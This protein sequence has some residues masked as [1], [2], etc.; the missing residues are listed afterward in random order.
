MNAFLQ[1]LNAKTS[2]AKQQIDNRLKKGGDPVEVRVN[3]MLNTQPPEIRITFSR[4]P[5]QQVIDDLHKTEFHWHSLDKYWVARDSRTNRDFCRARFNADIEPYE[6]PDTEL[7][8]PSEKPLPKLVVR[9]TLIET[10]PYDI[11]KQQVD[12]LCEQ[13]SLSP[14]DV[15]LMA[16]ASLHKATFS[17]N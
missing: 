17:V 10:T 11:Y 6:V 7:E 13:L 14:T 2:D 5:G 3:L 15:F 9:D 16:I 12:E 8:P 1:A 4:F